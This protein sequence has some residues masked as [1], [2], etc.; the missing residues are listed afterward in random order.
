MTVKEYTKEFYRLNIRIE[1]REKGNE[2]FVRYINCLRYEIKDEINMM[3]VRIVED[4][5]QIA[6]KA[7]EKLARNQSQRNKRRGLNRVKGVFYD[8]ASK[9]KGENEKSYGCFERG[10]SSQRRPF[11]GRNYF[12][13]GRG[14]SRGG[15][16][17]CYACGK[18]GQMS[19]E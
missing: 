1:Q 11:G 9:A 19:W 15:G 12:P 16:V 18:I 13:R 4:V 3:I 14:R 7:K 8:K 2:K 17:K 6:L 10:G 5:Y